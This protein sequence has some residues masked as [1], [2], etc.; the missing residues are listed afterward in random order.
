MLPTKPKPAEITGIISQHWCPASQQIG[1][2]YYGKWL[3]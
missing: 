2:V 3:A 1:I